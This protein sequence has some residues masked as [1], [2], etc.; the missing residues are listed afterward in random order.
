MKTNEYNQFI[1]RQ[2]EIAIGRRYIEMRRTMVER[3][4]INA[5]RLF[6]RTRIRAKR[7]QNVSDAGRIR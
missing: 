3:R 2:S 7:E 4:F 6:A 5:R 1:I